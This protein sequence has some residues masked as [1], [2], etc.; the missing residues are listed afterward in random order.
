[1]FGENENSFVK[2]NHDGIKASLLQGKF[3]RKE[4]RI[5][6]EGPNPPVVLSP[7]IKSWE[8]LCNFNLFGESVRAKNVSVYCKM[9]IF[10][11]F[12]NV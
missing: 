11:H 5:K 9:F 8:F 3:L 12:S 1:M 7:D 10:D 6:R 4:S 2:S